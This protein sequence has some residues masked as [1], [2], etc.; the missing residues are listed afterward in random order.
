MRWCYRLPALQ[1]GDGARD[2]PQGL[3]RAGRQTHDLHGA[4]QELETLGIR[5]R[6]ALQLACSEVRVGPRSLALVRALPRRATGPRQALLALTI[7]GR[8]WRGDGWCVLG[9]G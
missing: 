4:A 1:V 6:P 5:S 3:D 9:G 2:A 7:G 8:G